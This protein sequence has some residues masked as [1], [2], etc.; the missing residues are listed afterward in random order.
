VFKA[1]MVLYCMD[2][3]IVGLNSKYVSTLFSCF[4][5]LSI[6]EAL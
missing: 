3:G 1:Y 4:I 6:V 2:S 5:A